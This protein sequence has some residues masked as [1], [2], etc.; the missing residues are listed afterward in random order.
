M[1]IYESTFL[2][3]RN[4]SLIDLLKVPEGRDNDH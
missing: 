1:C 4:A 3:K 2:L